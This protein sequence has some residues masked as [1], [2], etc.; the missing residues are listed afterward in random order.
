MTTEEMDSTT[1]VAQ[2][3]RITALLRKAHKVAHIARAGLCR[4]LPWDM[5]SGT[6]TNIFRGRM[7][8]DFFSVYFI[9]HEPKVVVNF[10]TLWETNKLLAH[11]MERTFS[12]PT[13]PSRK[14]MQAAQDL[15]NFAPHGC[16]DGNLILT[17]GS[18]KLF[19]E[20]LLHKRE[21]ADHEEAP[22]PEIKVNASYTHIGV[23]WFG[24]EGYEM[25]RID[26]EPGDFAL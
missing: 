2:W 8:T 14:D 22:P 6:S 26:M 16:K 24:L 23:R 21:S 15:I 11:S 7:I 20:I 3:S 18:A 10:E 12:Y 19:N 4:E 9:A 5:D 1:T 17:E 25:T 13:K